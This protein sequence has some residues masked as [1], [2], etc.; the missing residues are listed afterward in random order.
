MKLCSFMIR[1]ET[2]PRALS[3]SPPTPPSS[4]LPQIFNWK[5]GVGWDKHLVGD[6]PN[7]TVN[8]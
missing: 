6:S 3:S 7:Q 4:P 8:Q 5:V 1:R 2:S